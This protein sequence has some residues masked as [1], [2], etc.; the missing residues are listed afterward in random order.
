M[1]HLKLTDITER[2]IMSKEL[3]DNNVRNGANSQQGLFGP[4]DSQA[5]DSPNEVL[6]WICQLKLGRI[7]P[8]F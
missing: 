5:W 8:R 6:G 3:I 7:V 1:S 4:S 2:I